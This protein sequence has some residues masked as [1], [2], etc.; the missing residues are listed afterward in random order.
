MKLEWEADIVSRKKEMVEISRKVLIIAPHADDEVLGCGG[1]IAKQAA[2]GDEIHLVIGAIGG[3]RQ[4]HLDSAPTVEE[5]WSEVIEAANILGLARV[6]ALYEGLDMRMDTVP[7]V[8]LVS[9]IDAILDSEAYAEVYLPCPSHNHDHEAVLR[10]SFAA[11]RPA[12]HI[13]APDLI[14]QYEYYYGWTQLSMPGGKMYVNIAA[15]METK[16]RAMKAY[17]SQVRSSPHPTSMETIR[18]LASMRGLEAGF[19][20]AELFHLLKFIKP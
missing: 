13:N 2:R 18:T 4:R 17:K 19:E 5:R 3:L 7:Q 10:A 8:E 14:A 9:N 15:Y 1:L 6:Q 12:A 11:L 16:E 20:F